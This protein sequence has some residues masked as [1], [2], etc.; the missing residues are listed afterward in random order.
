M[1]SSVWPPP[2]DSLNFFR[3]VQK[4]A[5]GDFKCLSKLRF[6]RQGAASRDAGRRN[7]IAAAHHPVP[8]SRLFIDAE[9]IGRP[10]G[11]P[12]SI[13]Q[14]LV[15]ASCRTRL[16]DRRDET[17]VVEIAMDGLTSF[18][19]ATTDGSRAGRST[20]RRPERDAMENQG[21][22]RSDKI[23]TGSRFLL[24]CFLHANRYPLRPKMP[25]LTTND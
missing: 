7:M 24:G 18:L 23:G 2:G 13:N 12:G 15:R 11:W 10:G 8:S 4:T 6:C 9:D 17:T 22:L 3:V 16:S 14:S 5:Y 19:N 21:H 20:F 1:V 25:G